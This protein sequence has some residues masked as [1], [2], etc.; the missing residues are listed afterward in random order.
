[1]KEALAIAA[2]LKVL[3]IGHSYVVALNRR[4]CREMARA[5][6]DRVEVVAAAPE[7]FRGDLRPIPLEPSGEAEPYR[8]EAVPV[9]L[10]TN[11]HLFTYGGRI[12]ELLAGPWDVVH[13][14]EEP[15][16]L[17]GFQVA[18]LARP[19]ASVVFSTYQNL[20]KSYPPP[21]RW[22]ERYCLGRASGWTAGGRTIV[23]ALGGRPGYRDRPHRIIPLGVDPEAFRPD[24]GAGRQ[25]RRDLGWDEPGPPVVGYLGRFVAEKGAGQLTRALDRLPS[26]SWRALLV[27]GGPLEGE[28]RAWADRQRGRARVVTG[29]AHDAVPAHLNAMDLLAAPSRTIPRWKEQLGR[30]LLEAMA[31][32]V[33]VVASDSGEIPHVVADAGPIVPEADEDAWVEALGLLVDSPDRR[34]AWGALGLAR[35]REVYA[36]SRVGRQYLDFFR[37]LRAS[38]PAPAAA[39]AG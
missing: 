12:R 9:R 38:A 33:P 10:G 14:W 32:G 11:A 39:S 37:D 28:L 15:F 3:T 6:G 34:R 20:R 17:A 22:T 16:V 23:E 18:R 31:C 21:F 19:G 36:W 5:G 35:A 2:P 1:M 7:W 27:G 24:P 30:M 25:V 4:L 26:G 29:V 8:L 13:A